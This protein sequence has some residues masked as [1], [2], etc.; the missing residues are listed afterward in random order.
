M[1]KT[2]SIIV[3]GKV[4]GVWYR[5]SAKEKAFE[6]GVTGTIRNQPDESVAIIATGTDNQLA[7]FIA[8]CRQGPPRAHVLQTNV[9]ELSLQSFDSFIIER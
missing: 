2:I 6:L 7:P 8:W 4:Q 3:T 5:Q 1:Q 9:K